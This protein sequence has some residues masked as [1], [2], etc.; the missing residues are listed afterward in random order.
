M[1]RT[2]VRLP[3]GGATPSA[4]LAAAKKLSPSAWRRCPSRSYPSPLRGWEWLRRAVLP[5]TDSSVV[6]VTA[7]AVSRFV[8]I[9]QR[10]SSGVISP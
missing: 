10:V 6:K 2:P 3:H 7:S 1:G 8:T 4:S 5:S 9:A